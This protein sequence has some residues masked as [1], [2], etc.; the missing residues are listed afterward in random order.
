M[1]VDLL[2]ETSVAIKRV[3]PKRRTQNAKRNVTVALETRN[4]VQMQNTL[5]CN[6]E[7]Q[8]RKPQNAQNASAQTATCNCAVV[9]T[10]PKGPS[11]YRR[12]CPTHRG[13]PACQKLQQPG[14][15]RC[16]APVL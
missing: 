6:S 12:A 13:L 5:E 14:A 9:M 15:S 3:F 8:K 4:T 7:T 16:R 1:T 11:K 2:V 10:N